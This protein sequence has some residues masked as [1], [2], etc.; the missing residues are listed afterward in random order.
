LVDD[1]VSVELPPGLIDVGFAV[2]LAVGAPPVP[3]TVTVT[4]PESVAPV[5]LVPMIVYA[6]VTV[7]ETTI[8]PVRATGVPFSFALTQLTVFQVSVE[9][10]P[11]LMVAGFALIPAPGGP[12]DPT[13]TVTVAV[14]VVP[15]ELLAMKV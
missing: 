15:E 14:A 5:E 7:G 6:V 8:D 13:V 10:P 2:M 12:P 1:Q 4:W 11:E 9:L 3:E